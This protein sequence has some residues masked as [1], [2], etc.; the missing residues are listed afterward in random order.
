MPDLPL[1]ISDDAIRAAIDHGD[2]THLSHTITDFVRYQA[3]WWIVYG[4]RW[5]RVTD[6]ELADL[7][8]GAALRMAAADA[9]VARAATP[10]TTVNSRTTAQDAA[11]DTGEGNR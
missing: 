1:D 8:D 4:H 3:T 6:C 2:A 11:E 9:A 5:L 10:P 7:L